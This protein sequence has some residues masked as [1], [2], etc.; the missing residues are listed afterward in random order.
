MNP[1]LRTMGKVGFR[2]LR[3]V[4]RVTATAPRHPEQ[5]HRRSPSQGVALAEA[6]T[7]APARLTMSRPEPMGAPEQGHRRSTDRGVPFRVLAA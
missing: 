2:L 6:L 3:G 4:A 5:G 1:I 7:A